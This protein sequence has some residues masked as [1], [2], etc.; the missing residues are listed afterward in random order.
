MTRFFRY[1]AAVA[2]VVLA[3]STFAQTASA[4]APKASPS[5]FSVVSVD[6]TLT[7][8]GKKNVD[9]VTELDSTVKGKLFDLIGWHVTVPVYSQDYMGYG[10]I[11]IGADYALF[12][13]RSSLA[14][15]PTSALKRVHGCQQVQQVT[16]QTM[17]TPMSDSTTT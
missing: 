2:A 11:D 14:Q 6:E 3:N 13:A 8:W 5:I 17:L 10:A 4:P 15:S 1:L 16:A 9:T 7:F 12:A